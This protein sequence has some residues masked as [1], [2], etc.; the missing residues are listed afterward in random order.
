MAKNLKA[1]LFILLVL[2]VWNGSALLYAQS[3]IY[4]RTGVIPG[5]GSSGTLPE[6]NIDL[7]TGNVTLRYRDVYL[8]GPNGLD[9]EVWRVYNS[10]ILKDRQSG[11]PVVQA[12][13]QSWVGLGWTMHMGMVH[14]YSSSTPIIEFPDGRLET[15]YPNNYG[16]GTS[17]CL[18][19]D[20]MKYDKTTV[21]PFT[22]PKLYFKDGTIWTFGA[23]ATITRADGTSDP[24]RLVT[25]IESPYGH[26]IDIVYDS[27][28]PTIQ[29]I[30]DSTGRVITFVTSGTPKK[31][32][33]IRVTDAN[34]NDRIFSY[35]VGTYANNYHRLDNFTPP[36]LPATTF[37][38]LDGSLSRYELSRMTTSYG[39]VLEYSYADQTFY[40][41]T[42]PLI[43]R[44]VSQKRIVFNPGE[45][46]AVW[47][48]TYPTYQ[49]VATG[50]VQVQ[51]PAYTTSATHNAY[52]ASTPWK[53]G[54]IASRQAADGSFSEPFDWTYQQI[55]TTNWTVLTTN[56][57]AA[58]GPLAS[59]FIDNRIGDASDKTEYL[60]ERTEVKRYGLPTK[61][62]NYI[63]AS[64]PLKNATYLIYYYEA[65]PGFK[66][67]H[68]MDFLGQESLYSGQSQP[69]K[70]TDTTYYEETGK[71][72]ALK[73][74]KRWKTGPTY[75]TWDFE[76]TSPDPASV[77]IKVD[78]PGVAEKET[79]SYL[80]G[81]K[82]SASAPDFSSLTRGI[83]R[84]DSSIASEKWQ[85]EGIKTYG[86]D[87]LGRM[88]HVDL[89]SSINDIA[90]DWRPA[91]AN[92]VVIT[93]GTNTVTKYW[94]GMGRDTGSTETG[95]GLTL[96]SR[97]TLDA[98][99][100]VVAE[101]KGAVDDDHVYSYS[102]NAT[103]Q[104]TSITDPLGETTS[105]AYQGTTK[106]VTDPEGHAT[107]YSYGDLPGLPTQVTDA[108]GK[109]AVYTYDAAGR[110]TSVLF[111]GTRNHVYTYD[112]L[113]NVLT[114]SHPETGTIAYGYNNENLLSSKTWG[115]STLGFNY[116]LSR[117]LY[118]TT[119][120]TGGPIDIVNYTYN[121]VTGRVESIVDITTGWRRETLSRQS[122][123][124]RDLGKD[125][126]PG[127]RS[128][129]DVLL[130]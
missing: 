64:G 24:V 103:G 107:T 122:V 77:T 32:T 100:R 23:T 60:Y 45:T 108:M 14:N 114:E 2:L 95:A 111:N 91:G 62:N 16:L 54:L 116:D 53:I 127:A 51:G 76:Y 25:K 41:N 68:M 74:V 37:E 7:F 59:S 30:T 117:R 121:N 15:A 11:N 43:S 96:Y 29:T 87:N 79:I 42:I 94:D 63:G 102:Y 38:Y 9:V 20:F 89:P 99:G 33:Q 55:S 27:G 40:F 125:D 66:S 26:H 39:G 17:I 61:I 101:S 130:L 92:C 4:D 57:G 78:P 112:G 67:R 84:W 6:E 49:G 126:H 8:P 88:T 72:G 82:N 128:E 21:P 56:M 73:Q 10:K 93:Q 106:T 71:W 81:V 86:Y 104:V 50:T 70:K 19:R 75:L 52:T 80:H 5:H 47:N 12:Y 69:V 1:L 123:R 13:H 35:S 46:A 105:I 115:G 83:N 36:M 48:F 34:G 85:D 65:H 22:Y 109:S 119:A 18:T 124:Q 31:L 98:E 58:K 110:L 129:D 28:L 120:T 113:D 44:V 3:G 97:R 90:Y 118:R